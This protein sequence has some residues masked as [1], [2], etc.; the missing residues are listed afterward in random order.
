MVF[1]WCSIVWTA[2]RPELIELSAVAG[3]PL[4]SFIAWLIV[5]VEKLSSIRFFCYAQSHRVEYVRG[6]FVAE[7]NKTFS[8]RFY[9]VNGWKHLFVNAFKFGLTLHV[10]YC[11]KSSGN[12]L[13]ATWALSEPLKTT[14]ADKE[15]T[16]R[17]SA[18][19]LNNLFMFFPSVFVSEVDLT[20]R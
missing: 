20:K 13:K 14:Q 2:S 9:I 8:A 11:S 6:Y 19:S 7:Q 15:V 16:K 18:R 10:L 5:G 1:V 12:P 17:L 4:A 3:G